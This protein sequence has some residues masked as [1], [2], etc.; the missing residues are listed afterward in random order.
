MKGQN[1]PSRVK[2]PSQPTERVYHAR[3]AH[4]KSREGCAKCKA[5]RVKCD[6]T[7]P[8]CQRCVK[9]GLGVEC[10][11]EAILPP[12]YGKSKNLDCG[13]SEDAVIARFL[14]GV[15]APSPDRTA[16]SLAISAAS[17]QI[18]DVLDATKG[19]FRFKGC[20][21]NLDTLRLFQDTITPTIISQN[22]R[23]IRQ[24]S[25][26]LQSPMGP[27]NM[28]PLF[29][30][31]LLMT[32]NSFAMDSFNPGQSFVF[33]SNPAVSLNWLFVQSGL[34]HL[35]VR[36]RPWVQKSMWWEMPGREELH[37]G[38]ADLCGIDQQSD[39]TS[40]PYSLPLRMLTPLLSLEP[41]YKTFSRITTFMGR[42]GPDFY[43][44]LI[45]KHPPALVV[46][47][48]LDSLVLKLLEF[49][50]SACDYVLKHVS[51]DVS[52]DEV[53]GASLDPIDPVQ[54]VEFK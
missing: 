17:S 33:S 18:D 40:N 26:E 31:C 34:R 8:Q 6:E 5:R 46:L 12:G 48:Y 19:K 4:R 1:V 44:R 49:P 25:S 36:S 14:D 53:L 32:V 3:R 42:L 9:L 27:K 52:L 50:A 30:A 28:D 54:V 38:L 41:S 35:L 2:L 37:P 22:G 15:P 51:L 21:G 16:H 10:V 43:E 24:Y 29:S 13:D 11:Y 20:M 39:E 23:A 47:A 7:R 45:A